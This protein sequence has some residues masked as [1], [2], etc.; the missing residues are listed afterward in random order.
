MKCKDG[1][2]NSKASLYIIIA[3]LPAALCGLVGHPSTVKES[4]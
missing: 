2:T 4:R 3:F 1:G